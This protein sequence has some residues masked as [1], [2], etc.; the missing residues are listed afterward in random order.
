MSAQFTEYRMPVSQPLLAAVPIGLRSPTTD[1]QR[2]KGAQTEIPIRQVLPAS[3]ILLLHTHLMEARIGR[4]RM[5]LQMPRCNAAV[6]CEVAGP[7]LSAIF[8]TFSISRLIGTG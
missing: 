6:Y 4:Q 3:G 1:R 8:S 2:R 7:I 5:R